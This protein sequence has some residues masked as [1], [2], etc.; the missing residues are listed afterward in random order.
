MSWLE[1]MLVEFYGLLGFDYVLIDGEHVPLERESCLELVRA[2]EIAGLVPML[3]VPDGRPSLILGYLDLG[4]QGIYVPH[5]TTAEQAADIV[6]SVK[7]A[8]QGNRGAAMPRAAG[9]GLAQPP[10]EYFRQANDDTMVIALVE[11]QEGINNLDEILAVEGIDVV[12]VGDNDLSHSMG[13][14]GQKGHP[15]VRAVVEN[16]EARIASGSVLDAVVSSVEQAQASIRFGALM[17]SVS[18]SGFMAAAFK[19]YLE[20]LRN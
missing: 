17:I 15:D 20:L 7:Y 3:R 12:G 11:D 1:P 19:Q 16:A 5:V 2:C 10:E 13:Y 9:Y 18:D 14:P 4:V 6:Q 8:P